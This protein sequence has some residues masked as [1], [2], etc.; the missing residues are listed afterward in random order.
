MDIEFDAATAALPPKSALARIVFEG[1]ALDGAA[2]QAAAA[3]RFTGAK[4]QTLDILAPQGE[5]AARLV[6]VGAGKADKFDAIGA[7]HAAATGYNAVKTSGL[8]TLRI[9][10]SGGI[11]ISTH[12]ALGVRLASYRFDRYRTTEKADK[13]PSITK[14]QIVAADADQA[15]D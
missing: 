11:D 12:A 6:L 9:E 2:G 15:L 3:S 10:V 1:G 5:A 13:K 14:T 7:E 4:G 8:A